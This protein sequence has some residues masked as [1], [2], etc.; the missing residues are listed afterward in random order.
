MSSKAADKGCA[1]TVKTVPKQ[2]TPWKPGQSGNPAGRPKGS[3]HKLAEDFLRELQ[4]DFEQNGVQAITTVRTERPA[5]YLKIIA[6]IVPK[7]VN[8][9]HNQMDDLSDDELLALLDW[10]RS[11]VA[12]AALEAPRTGGKAAARH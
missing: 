2:L 9:N 3:R 12:A 6:A 1:T 8:V 4:R 11:V 10:A 7:E 5:E